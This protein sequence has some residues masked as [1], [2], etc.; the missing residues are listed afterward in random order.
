MTRR[1]MMITL[2]LLLGALAATATP[3]AA[4]NEYRIIGTIVSVTPTKLA[5]KQTKDAKVITMKMD[6]TVVVKKDDQKVALSLLKA[7]LSVVVDACG[8]SLDKL[9]VLEVKIVPPAGAK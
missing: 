3:A 1:T 2:G 8:D 5:V 9:D 6:K 4:H 7:G